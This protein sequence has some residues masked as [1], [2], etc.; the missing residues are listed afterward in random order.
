MRDLELLRWIGS[1]KDPSQRLI[2]WRLKLTHYKYEFKYKPGNLNM[3]VDVLS[4]NLIIDN[5]Q[6]KVKEE[7]LPARLLPMRT[8]QR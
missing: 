3:N 2:P 6:D 8:R 7:K 4:R 1:L 5:S